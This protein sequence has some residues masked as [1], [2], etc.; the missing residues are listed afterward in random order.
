[1]DSI[2]KPT[3]ALPGTSDKIEVMRKRAAQ[4]VPLFHLGDALFTDSTIKL[5]DE[6][7]VRKCCARYPVGPIKVFR[8][9]LSN[10]PPC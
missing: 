3:T 10:N 6:L 9:P 8:S 4:G 2:L 5:L 1:M 7:L